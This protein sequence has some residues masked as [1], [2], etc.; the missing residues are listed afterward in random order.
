MARAVPNQARRADLARALKRVGADD[1]WTLTD[2]AQVWGTSKQRFITVKG[3]IE[4]ALGFPP[5]EKSKRGN[6][7]LFPAK[8]AL[9]TMLAY[10]TRNDAASR[11]RDERRQRMLEGSGRKADAD[12]SAFP[13]NELI[14][15]NR[16]QNELEERERKQGQLVA[17][18][19]VHRATGLIF[20]KISTFMSDLVSIIDPN[21]ELPS[22]MSRRLDEKGREALLGLHA[23]IKGL[24][25][26]DG[27]GSGTAD[28]GK[29]RGRSRRSRAPRGR[30]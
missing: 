10:E 23:D 19:E 9:E 8:A 17:A 3:Q 21:G 6:D 15:I 20:S 29:P 27:D 5:Y 18:S 1:K 12:T 2:L 25:S 28:T 13:T 30:Q 4:I 7:H 22:D 24:L 14:Q 26:N 11:D 16:L